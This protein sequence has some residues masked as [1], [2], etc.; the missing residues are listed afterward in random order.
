VRGCSFSDPKGTAHVRSPGFVRDQRTEGVKDSVGGFTVAREKALT[1]MA[2]YE[3]Q[4]DG[5]PAT[6]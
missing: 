6:N 1:K 5:K 3:V 2:H 4:G